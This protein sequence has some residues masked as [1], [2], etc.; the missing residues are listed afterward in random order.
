MAKIFI[1]DDDMAIQYLYSEGLRIKGHEI[2]GVVSDGVS[3]LEKLK[4]MKEQPDIII[5]DHKMPLKN[6]VET[7]K[8]IRKNNLCPN[9]K[10]LFITADGTIRE[11]VEKFKVEKFIQKPFSILSLL[12]VIDSI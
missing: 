1:V 7:L 6:G 12:S 2:L 4:N 10:I 11:T 5:L 9:A 3:A 8:E